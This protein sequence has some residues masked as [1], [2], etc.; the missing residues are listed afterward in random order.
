M[1]VVM[2]LKERNAAKRE[3]GAYISTGKGT[4]NAKLFVV[5][6]WRS[7]MAHKGRLRV[8]NAKT[9]YTSMLDARWR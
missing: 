7:Y 9:E 4:K 1:T 6:E 3:P 2:T 8:I 5:V